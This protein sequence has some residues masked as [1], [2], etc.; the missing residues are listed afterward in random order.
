MEGFLL[1]QLFIGN[2]MGISDR[3]EMKIAIEVVVKE[4]SYFE[5][6]RDF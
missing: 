3:A 5:K 2:R 1:F 4:A 6:T